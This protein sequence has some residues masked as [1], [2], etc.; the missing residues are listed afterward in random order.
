MNTMKFV[1]LVLL[2]MTLTFSTLSCGRGTSKD[3][4]T[5]LDTTEKDIDT[6]T[7]SAPVDNRKRV[8]V[9][10]LSG[11]SN[12]VGHSEIAH[13]DS[14]TKKIYVT[15]F[16]KIYIKSC[17]NPY[18]DW[19]QPQMTNGFVRARAGLGFTPSHFGPEL[20][21]AEVLTEAFPDENI[22]II[23]AATSGSSILWDWMPDDGKQG[24]LLGHLL[25]FINEAIADL[26]SKNLTPEII[27][28]CWMQG[29]SDSGYETLRNTYNQKVDGI[30]NAVQ[31]E[32][33]A[34]LPKDGMA[35]IQAGI[36]T[37]WKDYEKMNE[38]KK[39]YVKEH[40][41]AYYF[42]TLDLTYD[43]DNQ[44]YAHYD[45]MPMAELGRR[46]GNAILEFL[47][48]SSQ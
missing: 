34:Y 8:K 17:V 41:N 42:D 33:T 48:S 6:E 4:T 25:S 32:F 40:P 2:M 39:Q 16:P 31:D 9:I 20:G 19:A 38:V 1:V 15:G 14:Q 30:V 21:M 3:R 24:K 18:L 37:Y 43:Q 10:I 23:R 46:F 47:E 35:V 27:A 26:E 7:T 36:S 11:Q 29:E 28:F 45:A 22:F 5:T 13:L 12:A 44:D